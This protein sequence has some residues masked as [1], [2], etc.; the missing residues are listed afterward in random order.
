MARRWREEGLWPGTILSD[1]FFELASRR[2]ERELVVDPI[3]GRLTRGEAAACVRRLMHGL[4]WSH[5]K[6]ETRAIERDEEAI[7]RW[8]QKDWPRVKKTPRG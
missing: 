4:H 5:Q 1:R 7:A 3:F 6:P 2:P 8:K